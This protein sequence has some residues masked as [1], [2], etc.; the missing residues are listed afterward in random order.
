MSTI[1]KSLAR[2]DVKSIK[3]VLGENTFLWCCESDAENC[4]DCSLNDS[5][6]LKS[7]YN[8]VSLDK[9]GK[10]YII[11]SFRFYKIEIE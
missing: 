8:G 1:I 2:E 9:G 10:I 3:E 4:F 5:V 11:E 7:C 6:I